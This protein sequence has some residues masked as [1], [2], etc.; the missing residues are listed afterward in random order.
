MDEEPEEEACVLF[1][2]DFEN[3]LNSYVV[4]VSTFPK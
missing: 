1:R 2:S 4:Y 3:N